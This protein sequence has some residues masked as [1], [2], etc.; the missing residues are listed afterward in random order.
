MRYSDQGGAS[1]PARLRVGYVLKRFPRL[2]ETFVLN[3]ILELERQGVEV[4][5]FSLRRAK[6][7]MRHELLDR[8]R[9]PVTYLAEPSAIA[10]FP[11]QQGH[12]S[13]ADIAQLVPGKKAAD[14]DLLAAKAAA[15]AH[16]AME[17]GLHHL[18][19][20][21][22]S[23]ATTAALIAGRISGLPFS[24]TAHA[25]DIFHCYVSP[26][27]DNAARRLKIKEARF[28]ATV[29]QFNKHH[30]DGLTAW[31]GASNVVRLYNGIDLAR[32]APAG[33][34][35]RLA[36]SILSV[37]RLVE[38]KGLDDL[39]EACRLLRERGVDYRCDIVGDGPL[40]G[41]LEEQISVNG[42]QGKVE[43]RGARTHE[44][45]CEM[46]QRASVFVLPC[47]VAASGDRDGL[48]TVLLE[49]LASGLPAVSTRVA[50]IPEIIRHERTGLLVEP[51]APAELADVIERLLA[52]RRLSARL[53]AAGRQ[54]ALRHF[55]LAA[56]VAVLAR[57]FK[58]GVPLV[59]PS[60]VRKENAHRLPVG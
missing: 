20:H 9:A 52:D 30:L 46:M 16:L 5:V 47:V 32:F 33:R 48:P 43:L 50:G 7:E 11:G 34:S 12:R 53:A 21:F 38:K 19:A 4:E 22:A 6:A 55:D 8:L 41:V 25:R 58:D 51:S 37:G 44:H 42:L 18:H 3:E 17:R 39:V 36:G 15:I 35:Q 59:R 27:K 31:K 60:S 13:S 10:G 1:G 2:S 24:F 28:V 45:V 23:D 14:A 40:R 54:H 26:E 56:N 49:A 29:S 57:M